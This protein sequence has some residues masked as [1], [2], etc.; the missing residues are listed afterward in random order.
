MWCALV[1]EE[2]FVNWFI[3]TLT[4]IDQQLSKK[5]KIIIE[6]KQQAAKTNLTILTN[7][8]QQNLSSNLKQTNYSPRL[9]SLGQSLHLTRVPDPCSYRHAVI[10]NYDAN[11][12]LPLGKGD[13][14]GN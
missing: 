2:Q 1:I 11:V 8:E 9:S 6:L 5:E 12:R 7:P 4:D 13:V 3:S 14:T 10:I